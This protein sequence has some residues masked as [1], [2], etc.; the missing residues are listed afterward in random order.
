MKISCI[1]ISN[2]SELFGYKNKQ[3]NLV[4]GWFSPEDVKNIEIILNSLNKYL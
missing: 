4:I 3:G 2:N 1:Q